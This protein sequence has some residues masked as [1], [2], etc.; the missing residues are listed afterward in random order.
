MIKPLKS[1]DVV[2]ASPRGALGRRPLAQWIAA[3]LAMGAAMQVHAGNP[4]LSQAWLAGQRGQVGAPATGNVTTPVPTGLAAQTSGQLL[5]QRVVQQSIANLNNAA[6]AVAA[7]LSAQQAAQQAAQQLSSPVPDGLAAGGLQV[8]ASLASNPLLWQNANAPVQTAAAGKTTVEVKQTAAKAIMTWDSFNVGRNTTLYF[9]QSGGNQSSGANDWI[10]LNRIQD[11]SGVPSQILGQIKAEGSIYLLNRNG[12]LFGAGSQVN[13]RSLLAS[14]LNLFNGDVATSNTRFL[15]GGIADKN[16]TSSL[17]MDGVFTDGRNHDVVIEKGANITTGKQGF[18]L[19]AAPHVSNAGVIVTDD[20]QAILAGGTAFYNPAGADGGATL[21]IAGSYDGQG[22]N[23]FMGSVVN[24]GLIQARRGGVHMVGHDVTQAG[25]ALASTSVAY[26]G[27][28]ELNARDQAAG[29]GSSLNFTRGGTLV[30]A[31]GSVTAVL[32]EKDG[33]T[34]SSSAAANAAFKG[35]AL[36]LDGATVSLQSGSLLEAPGAAVAIAAHAYALDTSPTAGR[37]YVDSGA[38]IDVSGLAD[39]VLPMSALLVNVSRIGQNE[40]ANSPLLRDGFLYRQKDVAVDSTQS[41]TRADGLGWVGSPILNVAGYVDN[42]PR[43]VE[44]LITKGGNLSLYGSEVILRSGSQVNLNGGFLSY[45][46]GWVETPN[47]LGAN[48]R[49]YDIAAADPD[50]TYVGFAGQFTMDHPRWG[51]SQT[52]NDKL[53]GGTRRWDPGF[54]TGGDAGKLAVQASKALVLDADMTAQAFAGRNQVGQGKQP[55]GGNFEFDLPSA[56]AT[57]VRFTYTP[58]I[59]LQQSALMLDK[60]V[61]G[62]NADTTWDTVIAAQPADTGHDA[63]LRWWLPISTGMLS[64][65]GFATVKLSTGD[66]SSQIL[67]QAGSTLELRPGGSVDISANR[68]TVLGDIRAPAGSISIASTG[69]GVQTPSMQAADGSLLR[70]DITIGKGATLS[71]RGLWVNDSGLTADQRVGDRYINGGSISLSTNIANSAGNKDLTGS[72]LLEAGSTLDV[73]SGGYVG[74]DAQVQKKN[75]VP[76]GRGGDVSLV[77]YGNANALLP[78]PAQLDGGELRLDGTLLGYGF[79]GGGT[80]SLQA[81]YIQIGGDRA[82]MP[83]ANGLYLDPAFFSGQGF[84][85]Y[86]LTAITDGIVAPGTQVRVTRNN[87]LPD[88]QALLI[89][90]TGSDLYAKDVTHPNGVY[91]TVG[92]LDAYHRYVTRNSSAGTGFSLSA[93]QY[94]D[95]LV[96]P[97]DP[98]KGAPQYVGV[99]GSVLVGNG[100]GID[101]DAGGNLALAGTQATTVLGT[102]TAHGGGI[103]VSTKQLTRASGLPQMT[104]R[105]WL[106]ESA[107]LDASGIALTDPWAAPVAGPDGTPHVPRTGVVLDGGN[108]SLKGSGG[109]V[110]AQQGSRID[111]SGTA[112]RFELPIRDPSGL[113]NTTRY[114]GTPVWSDA[115]NVTLGAAAGLYFDG[116]LQATGGAAAAEGGTLTLLGL[117]RRPGQLTAPRAS[118]VLIQQSGLLVPQDAQ[119]DSGVETGTPS[120]V[121]HFAADRLKGSGIDTLVIGPDP[122]QAGSLD[123]ATAVPLG[124][125]GDVNLSLG[126]AFIANTPAIQVLPAGATTLLSTANGYASGN[127]QVSIKAPYVSLTGGVVQT[128]APVAMAGDGKLSLDANFIDIGGWLNLQSWGEAD[129]ESAGDIRFQAPPLLAYANGKPRPGLLFSTGNLSFKAAQ[130]YP[131]TDYRFAIVANGSGLKDASGNAIET[132]LIILPNGSSQTP[133]SA[134]GTL[135][136]S[137]NHIEQQGTL[138]APSG[139]L[140]IGVTDAAAQATALGADPKLF[141][142]TATQSVHLAPGSLTSVSL[143][144]VTVPYGSTIDGVQWR[145]SADPFNDAP[146]LTAPP[147]KQISLN[148]ADLAL[149]AG[150]GIDLSGGGHLQAAEWVAGTGGT[151][152]VLAQYSTTYQNSTAGTQIPQYADGRAIYAILPGYSAPVAASDAAFAKQGGAGPAVGQSVYLSGAPGLP[153]GYYTLLPARY[154]TLPGAFRVVQDTSA[155]DSVLGSNA[156]QPDGTLAVSGYFA[157]ALS[158]AHDARNTT[159]LAQSGKVWQQY[160]QYR[161]SDADTF[162]T[163]LANKAGKVAPA[164]AADAGRLTLAATRTLD[165]GTSL[166]AAPAKGGRGSQVDIAAQAIQVVGADTSAGDGYLTLSADG[167]S[168][169]GAGS[170]LLGGSRQTGDDG[171]H[172]TTMADSVVLSNDAAH[173]LQGAEILLVANGGTRVGAQGVLLESGS[174]LKATGQGSGA[175][176]VPL[177]FGAVAG[178]DA[179][180]QSTAAV[181]GDGA[182]L[183]VS[184]NGAAGIVRNNISANPGGALTIGAGARIDGGAALTLDAT[185]STSVDAS[186]A[187]S[188][189]AIDANSNRITF[190][191]DGAT[192]PAGANGFVIGRDTL[193]LLRGAQS[194]TLRSRGDMNFLGDVRIDLAHDLNLSAGTFASDGGT[195]DI[196]AGK[197]GLSNDLG[198]A[199]GT[200]VAGTGQFTARANEVDFGAGNIGLRGFGGFSATAT[201]GMQGQGTGRFDFGSLDVNLTSPWLLAGAGADTQ[202]ITTGALR[203]GGTAGAISGEPMGG[204]LSLSGGNVS[205]GTTIAAPAGKLDVHATS[206]DL[207]VTDSA[208][209][210]V[211]GVNKTFFDTTTYA[212]GGALK[213]IAD[214]GGISLGQ[215]ATLDFSGAAGGG[216]AGSLDA[217]AG[218]SLSLAGTLRGQAKDGYRGGYLTLGSGTAMDLDATAQQAAAA[219]ATGLFQLTTGTGDLHLSAGNTLRAQKVYL[220]AAGGTVAIDGTV[221]ASANSGSRIELYGERGVDVEGSLIA[222]SAIAAQRGGD[223]VIGTG[224]TGDGT[225]NANYGYQ[226]VQYADSGYIHL[227]PQARIDVSGGS[228]DAFS[229]GSVSLRAPLLANDDVRIAVDGGG[230]AIKGAR[231]VTLEPYARWSTQGGSSDPSKRFDGL[232]DPAGWYATNA[233]GGTPIMVA[234]TWTDASGKILPTPADATQLKQYLQNNYFIPKQVN[235]DHAGFYGYIDGDASKGPGT[236]M[237]Y[238]EQPGYVFGNRYAS[239]ANLQLRPGI[240][241]VN[242][243]N[244]TRGGDIAVLTNWNLGAGIT[245]PDGSIALAYRYQGL[246]PMLTVRAAGNLD[247]QASITDGF[248]QQNNGATLANPPAPPPPP[249]SDNGYADAL[250]G[251]NVSQQFLDAKGLW[252]GTIKLRDGSAALGYTPGG[253]TVSIASDPYYQALQAPLM[254]QSS[255][256]YANY[257]AYIGEVGD[258]TQANTWVYAYNNV[259]GPTAKGFLVYKPSTLTQIN[260]VDYPVYQDYVTAYQTWLKSNF[261]TN[262]VAKRITTPPPLLLP[263][264]SDYTKYTADYATYISGHN[265]YF[266]YVL[267]KVANQIFGTQLFYAPFAPKANPTD[268][269]YAKAL[270]DYQKSQQFLD[271]KGLWNGTIKLRDGSAALGYTPGGGTIS[272]ASD[273]YYQA[274]QAPLTGQSSDYYT[275]YEAYIGE[276]GDGTQS[277]TW[278]YAYNNVGGPTAKGFLVYKPSTL[279]QINPADYPVYQDYV[280]AYQ[281]WLKSNFAANPVAKRITTPPPLLLPLDSDYAK[282]TGNYAVYITGHNNYF[283]YVANSVANQIFGSQLFYAPF[284]PKSDVARPSGGTAVPVPASAANNS[285][286]NMPSLGSPVS[287]ASATLLGGSSTSYRLVAGAQVDAVDPLGTVA[288]AGD[289]NLDNHFAVVDTLTPN[290]TTGQQSKTN[291]KAVLLPAVVRTGS[292]SIDIVSGGNVNWLDV[293]APT[294]VYTAG[295]PAQGSATDTNVSVIRSNW[296]SELANTPYMLNTGQVNPEHGGDLMLSA[297]GDINAIQQVIDADGSATKAAGTDISQY[298]WP[299]MQTA[300]A[301]DGSASSINFANFGQGVMSAGGNVAVSAGGDIRQLSVSLPTTWKANADGQSVTTYGGGNLDVRA[302]GDILSGTYFVA[303]G[304]GKVEA[305]GA[306]GADFRYTAPTTDP[307]YAGQSTLVSALFALQDAQ[308]DVRARAGADIGGVYNPSYL[309][310]DQRSGSPG[311][312]ILPATHGDAQSYS[313]ASSFGAEAVGGNVVFDSLRLPGALFDYGSS[314][315]INNPGAI[316]PTTLSL[317][318]PSGSVDIRGAGALYPSAQGNLTVLAD[319]NVLLSQQVSTMQDG[320]G[321]SS[322]YGLGLI[323]APDSLLPSPLHP[324]GD[325]SVESSLGWLWLRGY[326]DSTEV[327]GTL[328]H[329]KTPL[330]ADDPAP[331]RMYALHGDIVDGIPSPAGFQYRSLQL[332]PSK[333]ALVRA[334][335]DIVNLSLLGQ[336]THDA[337]VTL[338]SAGR[339]IYDLPINKTFLPSGSTDLGSYQLAAALLLGGPGSFLIEAGRNIGPLTSQSETVATA[340]VQKTE[341]TGIDAVGNRFNPYLPHASADINLLYG[342]SPGVATADFMAHYVDVAATGVDSQMPELVDF[343]ERRVAGRVVDTGYAQDKITVQLTPQEARRLFNQEPDYVQR[344]FVSK[345]LFTILAKVGADYNDKSSPYFSQY[346]RGYAAIDTLFPAGFGYTANGLGQGGLNGAQT[347]VDTGD[348][349][350]RGTTIQTQQGGDVTVLGPGGQAL[351]GSASAPPVIT[352]SQGNVKAGP[353]TMGVL[354]LEQGAIRM[355]TDRSVLLAQSRVFTEQGGDLVLWSSNGDINAGQGA[356]TTAEIPPP[357]YLCTI[358]A[359]CRLDARGQVSGAGIATLQTVSGAPEGSVYLIAPRGTVDAGDAGIRVSGNLIVAA[360]RVAN[361][362]NIQVQGEKIGVPVAQSVNVGALNAASAAA[363]AVT[364]AAEDMA[365]Q[366]QDDARSKLPSVISVQVLGFGDGSA[367][368][369]NGMGAPRRYDPSSP[370]QVLGSGVLSARAKQ[371]LTAEE[372]KQLAE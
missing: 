146:D 65:G 256:Y 119:P 310:V 192:V 300:N 262:P 87:F 324:R 307:N 325:E 188:A 290:T 317:A 64:D 114:L 306:I 232:I 329:A 125:A 23:G 189:Q 72:V 339:D 312:S 175:S 299:W 191:G 302:G 330:H 264:D 14:S 35:S 352:D 229:G 127:G 126:R 21:Q 62:F 164:V 169:L 335:R 261:A 297:R 347:T 90:P 231:V 336:Q 51:I 143:D 254:G 48:G 309:F 367:S 94:L 137:A 27:S 138:R 343:M 208:L 158:G 202:L 11:P 115:G 76:T 332:T 348:L 283:K 154:A 122:S 209:L 313:A 301:A 24:T 83:M 69:P 77:T 243:A 267:T 25:V 193:D 34:T 322:T 174:V 334:G 9:N 49:V 116:Q 316:L 304:K 257:K 364:K 305:G 3:A 74:G 39:V 293:A 217:E 241:L 141:P 282:Y 52:F 369:N 294:A 47:L 113:G 349:D 281:T 221:D 95:W 54:V 31:P 152:D 263:L 220:S 111:V 354:T 207:A 151:R 142:L 105:V 203:V 140:I 82:A 199:N 344:Q 108:V 37:V 326:L 238:V 80:L 38:I 244:G 260:P 222:T 321:A 129:F 173:P 89:A 59:L 84:D 178:T 358:D 86:K 179:N 311:T 131:A 70:P 269:L 128:A 333:P 363:S 177:V 162:F 218:A 88:Y 75:G 8:A 194:V 372:R 303:K 318:A 6:Q 252:N 167:L 342:I 19:V 198:A 150:A 104:Q 308:L 270:A 226:N 12:I 233:N 22:I 368:L 161:L 42:V 57:D 251:Y 182:L 353:N 17:L 66:S 276:V 168:T 286:S 346:A 255:D 132:T 41:G 56:L 331:V 123:L 273:P 323:D 99:S 101:V 98:S 280:T 130:L 171:D 197:L 225:F 362:D 134:G 68:I 26:P 63:D 341:N 239:I 170:L 356:K 216:D 109:Y 20:G 288:G 85:Q 10:A 96:N 120:G 337:D 284:T 327:A 237:R 245:Q 350:L 250:A 172:V 190:L 215:G 183:R 118:G 298:W 91:A 81:N 58:G 214:H 184:Q 271:A 247:L 268:P 124:F 366:Q 365:R 2:K 135:L 4:P 275:N 71:T 201:Q 79:G 360:A 258:G 78:Q 28:I 196:E 187:L 45:Q 61:P 50:M 204:A 351:L 60:L 235:T 230:A 285:P 361:A 67:Q 223:V 43:T 224:G 148:G 205:I 259:G 36:S 246:A 53:L 29:N 277:N 44:Q 227:G 165:L 155:R 133:L 5:Q 253:G 160:S 16:S 144:G 32:P 289:V 1:V 236:L 145:Y 147:S 213:L 211:G 153:A 234:G 248:Y 166:T 13:T 157:D 117:G 100:A 357:N 219:G 266:T 355:F 180:G 97:Q 7:Q 319:Q 18:A 55:S 240:E 149:D 163:S 30:L 265:N 139:N 320:S 200:F 359:W 136:L 93:G 112:D 274:L 278:V 279:T 176:S 103:D 291:G 159:F 295:T 106:S 121:V 292:G 212:A 340:I 181:S 296:I 107:L 242:P 370:V 46:P 371:Q 92:A 15:N 206:G 249:V 102:L 110:V 186:A 156:V 73:S 195:V 272:I 345:A 33:T 314:Q 287:L 328:A 185:G 338:V 228:S 210:T 40:L 315:T